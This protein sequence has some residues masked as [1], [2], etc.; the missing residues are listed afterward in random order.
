[1]FETDRLPE[2]W[3]ERINKMD[4][5]RCVAAVLSFVAVAYHTT[6]DAKM[7]FYGHDSF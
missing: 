5:V 2:G 7:F 1:M 4:E 3:P 6:T